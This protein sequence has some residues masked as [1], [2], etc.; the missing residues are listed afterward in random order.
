VKIGI[1]L[2][3]GERGEERRAFGYSQ[4]R[5]MAIAT[6]HGG[7]DSVWVADHLLITGGDGLAR[8]IWESMAMLGALADATTRVELGPLVLCAPFRS[9]GMIAW[10]ANT[11]DEISGG[12]FV[13]GLG[14]GWHQPE[15]DAFGFEFGRRVSYFEDALEVIVPLL[16]EGRVDYD[17]EFASGHAE[18]RP[19]PGSTTRSGPPI[20]LAGSKPRMM[21]LIAKWADRFNSV[22]YGL[23]TDEFRDERSNLQEACQAIGRDPAT[24]EVSVGIAVKDPRAIDE[25]GPDAVVGDVAHLLDAFETWREE[26]VDE[27]LCRLEPPSVGIVEVIAEATERFRNQFAAA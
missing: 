14:A 15:F 22:W 6:E 24:I 27:V 2:P 23:P 17:G 20:L 7:L 26:G 16:R 3:I 18:L 1:C 25:N 19:R 13:L 8:G 5:D 11:L 9:P 21:S 12:R 4:M 10:A